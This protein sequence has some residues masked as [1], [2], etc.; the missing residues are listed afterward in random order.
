MEY[1]S[2]ETVKKQMEKYGYICDDESLLWEAVSIVNSLA[3]N[4]GDRKGQDISAICLAGPPGSGKTEFAKVIYK[5]VRDIIAPDCVLV[6]YQCDPT[7]GKENLFE[8][9]NV[10][11]VVKSDAS[12]VIV[13]G[14]LLKAIQ[15][16]NE[17][18]KVIL[19]L[20]EYDKAREETDSFLLQFLQSGE[21]STGQTDSEDARIQNEEHKKN[22][23]VILCKNDNR[24]KLS[25]PLERRLEF[26]YLKE[27]RP[28]V[29]HTVASRAYPNDQKLVDFV[30]LVYDIM[31]DSKENF[32]RLPSCAEM[33]DAIK[34]A[35]DYI[36]W[37]AP[38][39]V[40]YK[41]IFDCM[42]KIPDDRPMFLDIVEKSKQNLGINLAEVFN[43]KNKDEV[44]SVYELVRG[45]MFKE[46]QTV[47]EQKLAE[48]NSLKEKAI[49]RG[50]LGKVKF[51]EKL[52]FE[53]QENVRG[54][55]RGN[56]HQEAGAKVRR[57]VDIT[58]GSLD[59]T[60]VASLEFDNFDIDAYNSKL[61][62]LAGSEKDMFVY[63]NGY[64][65]VYSNGDFNL[66]IICIEEDG[67]TRVDFYFDNPIVP[68]RVF[69]EV[70]TFVYEICSVQPQ[71][72]NEQFSVECIV[73]SNRDLS[74]VENISPIGSGLYSLSTSI[75]DVSEKVLE[76]AK[77][78]LTRED[79]VDAEELRAIT[80]KV[81]PENETV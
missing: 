19:F 33:L 18:K 68:V 25:G 63:E 21:I 56:F 53:E 11:A 80:Q 32:E 60:L 30:A 61:Q 2:V 78:L 75:T 29:F 48:I 36:S 50:R 45:E 6:S 10:T 24:E 12:K 8:D 34:H 40:V 67:K 54:G 1:I 65:F 37:N 22:L 31:Y 9:I 13:Q 59:W 5:I 43:P 62:A 39:H 66:N 4:G 71:Q 58:S 26:I 51:S 55:I 42:V 23:Q 52:H 3:A 74:E 79:K 28:Q 41:K 35:K 69:N 57:G 14:A 20:D 46:Y 7:T 64:R 72:E 38:N 77:G 44:P 27:M 15:A 73:H 47:F 49:A 17:G 16:V 70:S 81:F 76:F